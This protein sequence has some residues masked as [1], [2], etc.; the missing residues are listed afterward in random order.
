MLNGGPSPY[1]IGGPI[2]IESAI[3]SI[4]KL[5]AQTLATHKNL[6]YE[7]VRYGS[8]IICAIISEIDYHSII[9]SLLF[10]NLYTNTGKVASY[11]NLCLETAILERNYES[12]K[13]I[14]N[15]HDSYFIELYD[16]DTLT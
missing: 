4:C 15:N 8:N 1:N 14:I 11:F 12:L 6:S 13:D 7:N 5:V 2:V 9:I 16:N 3:V 10:A